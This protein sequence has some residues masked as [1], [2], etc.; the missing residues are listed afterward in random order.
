[1][2]DLMTL[3]SV[4]IDPCNLAATA[5]MLLAN[6]KNETLADEFSKQVVHQLRNEGCDPDSVMSSMPNDL[7]PITFQV[8]IG[9]VMS[10]ADCLVDIVD[11]EHGASVTILMNA[12]QP[13]LI[14]VATTAI[15]G[16]VKKNNHP[17]DE[18]GNCMN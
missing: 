1:M 11:G 16:A 13:A 2:F 9:V 18:H 17:F 8:P 15:S 14:E 5:G 4:Q 6:C 3:I 10:V 7:A 12:W